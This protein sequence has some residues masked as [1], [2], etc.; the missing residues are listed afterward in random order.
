MTDLNRKPFSRERFGPRRPLVQTLFSSSGESTGRQDRT[1]PIPL[2]P[3]FSDLRELNAW[4][5]FAGQ[6]LADFRTTGSVIPSSPQL[7]R[8]MVRPVF[9]APPRVVVEF[10]PGTGPITGRILE[11]LPEDGRLYSFEINP[12]F[13][14]YLHRH[15]PDSRLHVM[16]MG[17]E[18]LPEVLQAEGQPAAD[19]VVS[20]LPLSFFPPDLRDAV[21]HGAA[22]SLKPGGVFTQF[23]YASGLD[24]SGRFPK[25][26]E[27]RPLL[28]RYFTRVER[29]LVWRNFPPA[30]VYHC[31][32]R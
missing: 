28:L 10:G 32:I 7:A 4:F 17:A 31:Y 12:R 9:A 1:A 16:D 18:R 22:S 14:D 27:L 25:P 3:H 29:R 26:Y 20:S 24:C 5:A 8:E 21:L 30:W 6:F 13:V 2:L 23:Q 15:Y 11:E 19:A